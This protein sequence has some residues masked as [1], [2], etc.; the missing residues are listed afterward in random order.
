MPWNY[1]PTELKSI[2]FACSIMFLWFSTVNNN[3][4][5]TLKTMIYM[6]IL[7]LT[8]I[9]DLLLTV[10]CFLQLYNTI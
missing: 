7:I 3:T 2:A 1:L 6:F 9:S 10:Q 5:I 4:N 8:T